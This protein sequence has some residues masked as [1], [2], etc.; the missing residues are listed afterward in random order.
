MVTLTS[1][2]HLSVIFFLSNVDC[3]SHIPTFLKAKHIVLIR[4]YKEK[5]LERDDFAIKI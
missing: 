1:F 2:S 4:R 5:I 3:S